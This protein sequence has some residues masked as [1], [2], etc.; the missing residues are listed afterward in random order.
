MASVETVVNMSNDDPLARALEV[1]SRS[2][3]LRM[4]LVQMP[5]RID[6]ESSG[7]A[8][9][10]ASVVGPRLDWNCVD[11][12]LHAIAVLRGH[13]FAGLRLWRLLRGEAAECSVGFDEHRVR[14]KCLEC[15]GCYLWCSRKQFWPRGQQTSDMKRL[16]IIPSNVPFSAAFEISWCL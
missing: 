4:F 7:M 1:V 2:G 8:R 14:S 16:V 3:K 9:I 15:S 5:H 13:R 6:N 12:E 11:Y 10:R